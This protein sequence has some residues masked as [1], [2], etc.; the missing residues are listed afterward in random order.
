MATCATTRKCS[1]SRLLLSDFDGHRDVGLALLRTLPPYQVLRVLDFI[2]GRKK[3]RKCAEA[4]AA[5]G[6]AASAGQLRPWR[7]QRPV[8]RRRWSRNSAC[9]ATRRG[10]CRRRS[11]ATLREREAD[12]GLVRQHGAGGPQGD[13]AAVCPAAR[14]ARS[15]APQQILFDENPPADS[16]V[17]A[18]KELAKATTP[19]EQARAIVEHKLPYRVAASVVQQMTPAVLAALIDRMS[20]QELINNLAALQRR[21]RSGQR[22]T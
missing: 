8:R 7:R 15:S 4:Q 16:R 5:P 6:S 13:E 2:H 20:P 17:F 10:R 18:L 11:S 22:R 1:S 21:G 19:A 3:T 12:R 14:Q 9:S